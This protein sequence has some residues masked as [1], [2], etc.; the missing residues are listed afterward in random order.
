MG[1]IK[2]GVVVVTEFC[3]PNSN[4]FSGYIN[5]IDRDEAIR[6][7][8]AAEF[9]IYQ[10][11]M[12]NPYKTTGL[13][14]KDN[15]NLNLEEK[16]ELKLVFREAQENGSLMWQ[17]VISFDNR[18][19]KENGLWTG[20]LNRQNER[21]IQ[22]ISRKAVSEMLENEGL[23]NAVWSA[24]IHLNTDNI[25]VHIATVEPVPMR[26]RK[27][28]QYYKEYEK[29]GRKEKVLEREALEYRGKFKM[30]SIKKCKSIVV[31]E[32]I[33]QKEMNIE[34]TRLIRES[35]V[36]KKREEQIRENE[37]LL[38]P[39]QKIYSQLE[40]I[41]KGRWKYNDKAI[42]FLKGDIDRLSH[43]YMEL[44]HKEEFEELKSKLLMQ[45]EK[46]RKGYGESNDSFMKG[47][48]E[49]LYTRLGNAVL[50]ELKAYDKEMETKKVIQKEKEEIEKKETIIIEEQ[51]IPEELWQRTIDNVVSQAEI[52][53][54]EK[55]G[56]SIKWDE[57][58]REARALTKEGKKEKAANIY[59]EERRK[60]NV[61]AFFEMGQIYQYGLGREKDT[62]KAI[63]CFESAVRY[64]YGKKS[65]YAHY[66][67][68]RIYLQE[69]KYKDI[70]KAEKYF[71]K[72]AQNGA[73]DGFAYYQLGRMYQK[74]DEIRDIKKSAEYL[75]RAM[76]GKQSK[77]YAAYTLGKIYLN[78]KEVRNVQRA[79]ELFEKATENEEMKPHAFYQ[80]GK[81]YR[82]EMQDV[83]KAISCF[84]SAI[85][86]GTGEENEYVNYQLGKIY[87]QE[88]KYK[89]IKKAERYFLKS[90]KNGAVGGLAYYQLGL[91]YQEEGEL[92][93]IKKS[94]KYLEKAM[95]QK[96]SKDYAAY[97]LGKI[98]LNEEEVRNVQKAIEMFEKAMENDEMKSNAFYQLGKIYKEHYRDKEKAIFNFEKAAEA[99]NPYTQKQIEFLQKGYIGKRGYR[100]GRLRRGFSSQ[101]VMKGLRM[102]LDNEY[103]SYKN[104]RIYLWNLEEGQRKQEWKGRCYL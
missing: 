78:E 92:R 75:E 18:W 49:D 24:A 20:Y 34:I 12:G 56:Y 62:E 16:E 85:Q 80:L 38:I 46:Y 98:Y 91:V 67:L 82:D 53:E 28:Y 63:S 37:K 100:R 40:K 104:Q 71:L 10:D 33:N 89:D 11:Y 17:T 66:Q 64:G 15:E 96:Q 93:D 70:R 35:I 6:N 74:E 52:P 42:T 103:E 29:N 60:G 81:I 19:L 48:M 21:K 87:L 8:H 102:A 36:Q 65:G 73:A 79:A 14:T 77:D 23:E 47:K 43:A 44:Y 94:V 59:E 97:A 45:E 84:E 51:E 32:V 90:T 30:S 50:N 101:K 7:V 76:R 25:H 88:E 68:G 2:A 31:N 5:Y 3:Q 1:E 39:F 4:L 86:Y 72:S 54:T 58:I 27:K 13:F 22:E 99:G 83:D 41:P 57:K 26:S 9:N 95:S 69:K 55:K 61:L